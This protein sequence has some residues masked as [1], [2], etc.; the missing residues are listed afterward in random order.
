MKIA[1]V[2]TQLAENATRD[3]LD[4]L[5]QVDM[6]RKALDD[7]GMESVTIP[8]SLDLNR[9]KLDLINSGANCVFN[10]VESL[11]GT[12]RFIHL[13]PALLDVMKIPYTGGNTEALFLT[14]NKVL[15][16]EFLTAANLPTPEFQDAA[17]IRQSGI[18][19]KMPVIIKPVW[20]DASVGLDDT[21][22]FHDHVDAKT[23]F[24]ERNKAYGDCFAEGFISGREFNMSVIASE[25][26]PQ[27]LPAAEIIF[28]DFPDD[29]PQIVGYKAKWES[30][31]FEYK[32]TVR[33]FDFPERDHEL[34]NRLNTLTLRCWQLFK[35]NGYARVDFRVDPF[36]Q[37]WILEINANPCIAPDSGF[38]AA[39]GRAGLTYANVV[40]SII[41]DSNSF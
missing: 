18:N 25:D 38:M 37:P 1:I 19:L 9:A 10:L 39:A 33:R 27:V 21:A 22:I 12:G 3:E 2:H 13:L 15:T 26:G 14:T 16:K 5:D 20:E 40:A 34:I 8:I 35:L 17:A 29:K 30:D 24:K 32:N 11:S 36:G 31:S 4:V 23:F 6:V 41:A 28:N 7:L